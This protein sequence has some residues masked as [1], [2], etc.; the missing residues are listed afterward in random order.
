[1]K[2]LKIG[3]TAAREAVVSREMLATSVGSGSVEVLA[4]PMVAALLEGAAADLVQAGLEETNTTVGAEIALEH[5]CPTAEGVSV[6]AVAT[7]TGMEGRTY[8]FKLEAFDN[9]G[10]IAKGT[11][12]RVS[13]KRESFARKAAERK[14]L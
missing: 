6:R 2:E 9:A 1:M 10:L 12:T 4:T 8:E 7:L 13:V 3:Q 11:H 5:L 14:A